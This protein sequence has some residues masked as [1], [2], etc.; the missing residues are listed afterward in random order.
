MTKGEAGKKVQE[1]RKKKV[2]RWAFPPKK[3]KHETDE[4]TKK[5]GGRSQCNDDRPTRF[6]KPNHLKVEKKRE[7]KGNLDFIRKRES[8][9][10]ERKGFNGIQ[11]PAKKRKTSTQRRRGGA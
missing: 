9:A 7:K 8:G 3:P 5:R 11:Y 6:Q 2:H 1:R 4:G 10:E